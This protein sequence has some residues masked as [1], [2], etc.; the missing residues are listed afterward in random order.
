MRACGQRGPLEG[1]S[2]GGLCRSGVVA[3]V[4]RWS[5]SALASAKARST[6]RSVRVLHVRETILPSIRP[7]RV[8]VLVGGP[9][10]PATRPC[11][12]PRV[13]QPRRHCREAY[14]PAQR[15]KACQ[16]ARIS[17]SHVRS[18]GPGGPEGPPPQGPST[19]VGLI[20]S[21]RDRATFGALRRRGRRV[22]SG[23][24]WVSYLREDD[25]R[26]PRIAFAIGSKVGGAVVRNRLRRRLRA[27]VAE[28][29][30]VPPGIPP[31]A[32]LIG[33]RAGAD[34]ATFD[35]LRSRM[36]HAI[37]QLRDETP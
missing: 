20:W 14:L 31:G 19:S 30:R 26:P 27:I 18:G 29:D 17:S 35:E 6:C 1:D 13:H 8:I 34:Q 33:A 3:V 11:G 2:F 21:V 16:A 32:Y 36:H 28:V 25:G 22:N 15:P 4:A 24:I 7:S 10:G 9:P 23:P 12:G 37:R 5:S